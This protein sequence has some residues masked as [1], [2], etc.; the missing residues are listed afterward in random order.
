LPA[1]S[2]ASLCCT[3]HNLLTY[4]NSSMR[5][6]HAISNGKFGNS[7]RRPYF[8]QQAGHENNPTVNAASRGKTS[9][10]NLAVALLVSLPSS[11]LLAARLGLPS[12]T[13][14]LSTESSA[15]RGSTAGDGGGDSNRPQPPYWASREPRK[16]T[17]PRSLELRWVDEPVLVES[18]EFVRVAGGN[19]ACVLLPLSW[20]LLLML[21]V[22]R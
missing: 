13:G 3:L 7:S 10:K 4:H 21:L 17:S 12:F 14:V 1:H 11:A 9:T 19:D 18:E 6:I 8:I 2:S 5:Y 22:L 20:L 16:L 15:V